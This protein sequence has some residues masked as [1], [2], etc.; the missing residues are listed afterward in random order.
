MNMLPAD[1]LQEPAGDTRVNRINFAANGMPAY[2]NDICAVSLDK[3]LTADEFKVLVNAAES[4]TNGKWERALINIS[5][6]MQVLMEDQQEVVHR[7]W[8]R[9]ENLE[10]AP[11]I[12][13]LANR[14][15]VFGIGPSKR[16]EDWKLSRLNERVRCLK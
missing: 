5:G 4:T 7:V 15:Q 9:I 11:E 1:F 10:V 16:K 13:R 3:V 2:Y 8:R 12:L 14:L 6:G